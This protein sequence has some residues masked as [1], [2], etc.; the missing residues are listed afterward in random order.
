M[1]E[2]SIVSNPSWSIFYAFLGPILT[3]LPLVVVAMQHEKEALF[4]SFILLVCLF[5]TWL[6]S[7]TGL[8]IGLGLLLL[9]QVFFSFKFEFPLFLFG[10]FATGLIVTTLSFD[11]LKALLKGVQEN[12][13]SEYTVQKQGPVPFKQVLEEQRQEEQ[14]MSFKKLVALTRVQL[15]KEQTEKGELQ[16]KITNFEALIEELQEHPPQQFLDELKEKKEKVEQMEMQLRELDELK[17]RIKNFE[18]TT[19]D[20]VQEVVL[21]RRK[22]ARYDQLKDQFEE[23]NFQLSQIRKDLFASQLEMESLKRERSDQELKDPK[24][25]LKLQQQLLDTY[26][27]LEWMQTQEEHLLDII[28]QLFE[29]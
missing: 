6:F 3:L 9:S 16:K 28:S 11:E 4:F 22:A 7:K 19:S 27:Q 15:Q 21:L 23:K 14:E 29:S 8:G 12:N 13:N 26:T 24:N 20:D 2:K 5:L 25:V 17:E 10:A 18:E 1:Q